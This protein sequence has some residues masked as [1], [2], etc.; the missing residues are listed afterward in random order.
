M[1]K[2]DRSFI[3]GMKSA[4]G[5]GLVAAILGL[6]RALGAECVAEGV[7]TSDEF[8][9][10]IELGCA[11]IQ[12]FYCAR[13]VPLAAVQNVFTPSFVL[14]KKWEGPQWS[15]RRQVDVLGE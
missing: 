12:G 7:E 4:S 5:V 3:E 2:I 13:P 15:G 10:L 11:A 6:A 9:Q 8:D 1:L 14:P